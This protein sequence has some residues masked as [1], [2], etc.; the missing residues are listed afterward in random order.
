MA[1]AVTREARRRK[2]GFRREVGRLPQGIIGVPD[3]FF[4]PGPQSS[5][6]APAPIFP[7]A[8]KGLNRWRVSPVRI[9]RTLAPRSRFRI[10]DLYHWQADSGDGVVELS[11][12]H[13]P[14]LATIFLPET[15]ASL[16]ELVLRSFF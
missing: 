13:S 14:I 6:C 15:P 9:N 5:S 2:T 1:V 4:S 12:P 10:D 16:K 3:S 7:G 8:S 11:V